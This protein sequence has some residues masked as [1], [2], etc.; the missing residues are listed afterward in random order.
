MTML[1]NKTESIKV[2]LTEADKEALEE[3]AVELDRPASQIAREAVREKIASLREV[4]PVA[5]PAKA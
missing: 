4:G 1:N 5:E 2:R 3:L